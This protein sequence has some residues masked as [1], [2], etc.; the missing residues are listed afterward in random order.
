MNSKKIITILIVLIAVVLL[1]GIGVTS[2]FVIRSLNETKTEEVE[3][4]DKKEETEEKEEVEEEEEPEEFSYIP[5]MYKVCDSDSCIHILGSM[6]VGDERITKYDP[7]VLEIYNNSEAIAVELSTEEMNKMDVK[8][9][10]LKDNS[11]IED[12]ISEELNNKLIEFSKK[13]KSYVYDVYK[14]YNLGMNSTAIENILYQELGFT[15]EGADNYFIKKAEKE[16]KEVISIEKIEDQLKPLVGFS[17]EFY[18]KQ[19]NQTLSNYEM[20]KISTRLLYN[21]Y[22]KGDEKKLTS[23]LSQTYSDS[24]NEEEKKYV[25]E[26]ILDRND[27]MTNAAKSYL[28]QNKNVLII[29]GAAHLVHESNGMIPSL[30]NDDLY[31]VTRVE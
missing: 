15:T 1:S 2:F 17:D 22:L 21:I 11:T 20:A 18:A 5:I 13:H 4:E 31:T 8:D 19:I 16:G 27:T 28:E 10:L 24:S 26:L 3:K 30:S 12:H 23:L 25:K 6:H 29:V 9:F 14:H 7:K